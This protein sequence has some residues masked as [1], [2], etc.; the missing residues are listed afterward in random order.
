MVYVLSINS[1]PLMPCTETKAKHL[2]KADKATVIRR[3]PFVIQLK[4]ECGNRTQAITLGVDAGAKHIGSRR[5]QNICRYQLQK[6]N[7]NF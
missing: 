6:V 7:A 3:E 5:Y 1:K 2:L 4:F